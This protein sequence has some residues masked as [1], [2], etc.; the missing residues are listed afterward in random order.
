[1]SASRL[2]GLDAAP[3]PRLAMDKRTTR[4]SAKRRRIQLPLVVESRFLVVCSFGHNEQSYDATEAGR[5]C[6]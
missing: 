2:L 5:A 4:L 3:T 6:Q 1:L